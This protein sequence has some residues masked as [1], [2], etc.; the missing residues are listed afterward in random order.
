MSFRTRW[1]GYGLMVA[2]AALTVTAGRAQQN[3]PVIGIAP[4]AV[5]AGPYMFD[6]AEQHK[7]R[8]VVVARGLSHPFSLAFLPNGDAGD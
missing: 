1:A 2:L 6:T 5:S 8:V 3:Q 4:V 7:L